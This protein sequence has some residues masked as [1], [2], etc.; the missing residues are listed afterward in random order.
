MNIVSKL[1]AKALGL[2]Q[3][4]TGIPCRKGHTS[5]RYT[6]GG[7]CIACVMSP[8]NM[9]ASRKRLKERYANPELRAKH[10]QNIKL[11][12]LA[13]K[14]KE[15]RTAY[16][17]EYSQRDGVREKQADYLR[18]WCENNPGKMEA[19]DV[20][21]ELQKSLATPPWANL[22][23]IVEFYKARPKG[24]HVDHIIPLQGK[25]VSGLNILN[26]LQYLTISE[27]C[28]KGNRFNPD[29][30]TYVCHRSAEDMS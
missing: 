5:K 26:N 4:F 3:Y 28:S 21:R 13:P 12:S 22:D 25:L 1:E 15:R 19:Y 23:A 27:N 20:K 14:E 18:Q 17:K 10:L 8:E 11:R 30:H 16:N 7:G 6:N 24:Y 29:E 2:K 9:E